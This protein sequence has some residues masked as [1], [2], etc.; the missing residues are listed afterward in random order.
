MTNLYE[1]MLITSTRFDEEATVALVAK[2]KKLIEKNGEI[3]SVD[4]WGKKRLAYPIQDE[5]EG[6]YTLITFTCSPDFPAELERVYGITDG[7]LRS[8]V[9]AKQPE[10]AKKPA[11]NTEA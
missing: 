7:V 9:I 11:K 1:T 6:L 8:M 4:E 2:F 10:A 5:T 3:V